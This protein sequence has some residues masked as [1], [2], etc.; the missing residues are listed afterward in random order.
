MEIFAIENLTFFYPETKTPAI[1]DFSLTVNAGDFFVL[2][3]QSG[4]GKSTLLRQLKPQLAP[5]GV[6]SGKI[7]FAGT[8]IEQLS[9][10]DSAAKIG[11][12][13]S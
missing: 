2:C 6:K 3:G 7:L 13:L 12:V 1:S 4:C 10:K 9:E 5:H 8:P 11:F